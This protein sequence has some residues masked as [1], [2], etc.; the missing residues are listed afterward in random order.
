M[1]HSG[2]KGRQFQS[3]TVGHLPERPGV[4]DD[5]W[6][7]GHDPRYVGP[8][9][10]F[11]GLE[12]ASKKARAVVGAPASKGGGSTLGVGCDEP[13]DHGNKFRPS[14][15]CVPDCLVGLLRLHLGLTKVI[16]CTHEEAA[17]DSDGSHP[18]ASK[19]SADDVR[20]D[21][22]SMREHQVARTR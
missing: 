22:L 16:R 13:R 9:L 21:P 18:S 6:V 8:D 2:P 17:V 7:G 19:C 14:R 3:L 12:C 20:A 1:E 11:F 4:L 5:L 15:G 10:Y